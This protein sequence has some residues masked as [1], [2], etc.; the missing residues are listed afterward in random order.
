MQPSTA[1]TVRSCLE[2]LIGWKL[3]GL[4]HL[5]RLVWMCETSRE[6]TVHVC[7]DTSGL[8]GKY[9]II[10]RSIIFGSSSMQ[11]VTSHIPEVCKSQV[12]VRVVIEFSSP[13]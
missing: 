13:E 1:L 8:S 9:Q 12:V 2:T 6:L 7:R 5:Q 11:R 4:S 10:G 3:W